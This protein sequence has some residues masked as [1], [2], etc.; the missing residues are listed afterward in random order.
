MGI[1]SEFSNFA[2]E[3]YNRRQVVFELPDRRR[4][5]H[6]MAHVVEPHTRPLLIQ[7]TSVAIERAEPLAFPY[8]FDERRPSALTPV[9]LNFSSDASW[10]MLRNASTFIDAAMLLMAAFAL[11]E[12]VHAQGLAG[13]R[14]FIF[15]SLVARLL[16]HFDCPPC[17][18]E[19]KETD[20]GSFGEAAAAQKAANEA[21][22]R[23]AL[24]F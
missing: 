6:T 12:V 24:R 23:R 1:Y 17:D 7:R 14:Y 10:A 16:L 8:A 15:A 18:S 21:A 20:S 9:R 2:Q 19:L 13:K 22:A 3:N 5:A 4:A 11:V